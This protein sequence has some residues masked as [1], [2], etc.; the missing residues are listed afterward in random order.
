M[1]L[2]PGVGVPLGAQYRGAAVGGPGLHEVG[3]PDAALI[4]PMRHHLHRVGRPGD[5]RRQVWQAELRS[6]VPL[7]VQSGPEP[8][9]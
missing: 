5:G 2:V 9:W 8:Y 1:L 6:K 4:G 7:L 3:P